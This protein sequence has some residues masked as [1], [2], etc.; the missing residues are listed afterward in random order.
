MGEGGKKTMVILAPVVAIFLAAI[1]TDSSWNPDRPWKSIRIAMHP[2]LARDFKPA[3]VAD[4]DPD[5]GDGDAAAPEKQPDV[6]EPETA[7]TV[8]KTEKPKEPETKPEEKPAE[9][10]PEKKPEGI[11]VRAK[12][13]AVHR[14]PQ[15]LYDKA[16][17]RLDVLLAPGGGATIGGQFVDP[18]SVKMKIEGS[19]LR[20]KGL[21]FLMPD[22]KTPWTK[23]TALLDAA[24]KAGW[25]RIALGVCTPGERMHAR[26]LPIAIPPAGEPVEEDIPI[27]TVYVPAPSG[28]LQHF[29]LDTEKCD[30]MDALEGMVRGLHDGEY[31]GFVPGYS[32]DVAKTPWILDGT[33]ASTSGVV[34][35][36]DALKAAGV[37]TWRVKGVNAE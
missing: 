18:M 35:A 16:R 31:E 25:K 1:T 27:T 17:D 22:A 26:V 12:G 2:E 23:V 14:S 34:Q 20:E 33:G 5:T 6:K 11:K 9:K 36:M 3:T 21:L 30:D 15:E 19:D 28:R 8:P 32:T 37:K 24:A 29:R 4:A 10:P 13:L 7:P